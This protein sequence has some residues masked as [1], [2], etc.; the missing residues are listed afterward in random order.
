MDTI[1]ARTAHSSLHITAIA[2]LQ[3]GV[4]FNVIHL[5]A[6]RSIFE[7]LKQLGLTK[8]NTDEAVAA[9]AHTLETYRDFG[10]I[11]N[12]EDLLITDSGSRV[13]GKQDPKK[14]NKV[15]ELRK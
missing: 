2:N 3:P 15:E 13:P 10:G 14:I 9:G 4:P 5:E 12:E 8:G 6:C 11:R 7:G 1:S